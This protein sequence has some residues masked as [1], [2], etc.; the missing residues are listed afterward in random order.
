MECEARRVFQ[1]QSLETKATEVLKPTVLEIELLW[2]YHVHKPS[3][4]V[5]HCIIVC[6]PSILICGVQSTT[7]GLSA[8]IG[9]ESSRC[10]CFNY[11]C[12]RVLWLLRYI[13]PLLPTPW[14]PCCSRPL[15][16]WAGYQG[17]SRI[18][19]PRPSIEQKLNKIGLWQPGYST[20]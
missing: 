13:E 15:S 18:R 14:T 7:C 10:V 20:C 1:L 8:A 2:N 6:I 16:T 3:S 17:G 5:T 11:S 19:T 4:H 12:H 9:D